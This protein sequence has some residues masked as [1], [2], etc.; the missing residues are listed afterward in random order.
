[1]SI[2][3]QTILVTGSAG[4]IGN[5][6]RDDFSARG[7]P[8]FGLDMKSQVDEMELVLRLGTLSPENKIA[9]KAVKPSIVIHCAAQ[10]DVTTSMANPTLDALDNIIGS[11]ELFELSYSE[12]LSHIIYLNSGG[13]AYGK[14]AELPTS[15]DSKY[16]PDSAYGLSKITAESYLELLCKSKNVKFTSL[17]LSN[18][19]GPISQNQKGILYLVNSAISKGATFTMYG[20]DVTRDYIHV[21][22]VVSA[23]DAVMVHGVG[24]AFNVSTGIETSNRVL[25]EMAQEAVGQKLKIQM[26]EPRP[27]EILRSCLSNSKLM[28]T[29]L[30]SPKVNLIEGVASALAHEG[31][32]TSPRKDT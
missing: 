11:L 30:W 29:N 1:M 24:G 19:Y 32:S 5:A 28:E 15:E 4:F 16:S 14:D 31:S 20:A 2:T 21:A 22:D 27:G 18:V 12:R 7:I 25:V 9:M 8:T 6:V 26:A 10:T 13:A 23:I 3:N 17:R